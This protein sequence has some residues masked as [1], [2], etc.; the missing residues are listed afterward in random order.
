[1]KSARNHKSGKFGAASSS[2]KG[3]H[4]S[5]L[6]KSYY[7]RGSYHRGTIDRYLWQISGKNI[8]TAQTYKCYKLLNIRN[9]DF[10]KNAKKKC[11]QRV[12]NSNQ[13]ASKQ[14]IGEKD[15]VYS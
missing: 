2:K 3:W 9:Q 11:Q 15:V 6:Q 5:E 12:G 8:K 4:F 14:F 10:G 1:M 13:V 7:F